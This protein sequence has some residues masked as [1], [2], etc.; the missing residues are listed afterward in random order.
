VAALGGLPARVTFEGQ[1]A[2]A[3]EFAAD[4]NVLD[5]YPLPLQ[6]QEPAVLDWEPLVRAILA[7]RI[8]KVP[9]AVISAKFHNALA[10]AAV[11]AARMAD[12]PA[13]V[14]T[15]GCFQNAL[16]TN[17]VRQRLAATGF[18]VYH[19]QEVPPGDGGI[20]L[21]QIWVAALQVEKSKSEKVKK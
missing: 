1:A 20:A 15:G 6:V 18:H 14:L 5:A 4:A 12:C 11:A 8:S 21:G 13:V 10:D 2:M 16:L 17:R 9:V 7:D 3:L 19:H